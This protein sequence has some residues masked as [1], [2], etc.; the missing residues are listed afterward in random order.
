MWA[1]PFGGLSSG[2]GP[3]GVL[4]GPW[5]GGDGD[6]CPLRR[7]ATATAS[8]FFNDGHIVNVGTTQVGESLH[9]QTQDEMLLARRRALAQALGQPVNNGANTE[10]ILRPGEQLFVRRLCVPPC[11]VPAHTCAFSPRPCLTCTP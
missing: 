10:R 2:G 6:G 1:L 9:R 8:L 3:P 4:N 11:H 5:I 7:G